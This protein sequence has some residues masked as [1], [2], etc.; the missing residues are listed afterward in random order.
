MKNKM[1][2]IDLII[3]FGCYLF[4]L[5]INLILGFGKIAFGGLVLYSI[6][7]IILECL[8]LCL[9]NK[10]LQI[11]FFFVNSYLAYCLG[12]IFIS[13]KSG[14]IIWKNVLSIPFDLYLML[15]GVSIVMSCLGYIAL[16]IRWKREKKY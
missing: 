4:S 15:V 11:V 2:I 9:F 7:F 5:S 14:T 13:L 1:K 10:Y 12:G 3:F 16:F 6:L 8:T